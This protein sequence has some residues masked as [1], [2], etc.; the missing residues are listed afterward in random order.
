MDERVG[1]HGKFSKLCWYVQ[2]TGYSS[3]R[4]SMNI[5]ENKEEGGD[6]SSLFFRL[7]IYHGGVFAAEIE[8]R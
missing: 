8:R 2:V 6:S 1:D 5:G 3:P 7:P 4:F